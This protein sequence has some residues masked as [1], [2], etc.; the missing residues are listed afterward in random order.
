VRSWPRLV[1][2]VWL[3]RALL[4]WLVALPFIALVSSSGIGTLVQG[5]R[6]LFEPGGLWLAELGRVSLPAL[7][8]TIG[9]CW[10]YLLA[11]LALRVVP[12]AALIQHALEPESA[13]RPSLRAALHAFKRLLA[14]SACELALKALLLAV[15]FMVAGALGQ[16]SNDTLRRFAPVI[17]TLLGALA[18]GAVSVLAD[19][20]RALCFV[21]PELGFGLAPT[22]NIAQTHAL[23]LSASYLFRCGLGALAIACAA[24][25]AEL[26]DVSR[27]GALRV[28]CVLLVHQAVLLSLTG[29]HY[30][31]ARRVAG[32]V[33]AQPPES[34]L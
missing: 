25:L 31:W 5:D 24:R 1:V 17:A 32:A 21:E 22:W 4:G 19:A 11:A 12:D 7:G 3:L 27:P 14:L 28:V 9:T 2:C 10:P 23:G 6:A 34:R 18:L 33:L 8:A 20:R 15:V 30:L 29:L 16:S 26:I 13:V